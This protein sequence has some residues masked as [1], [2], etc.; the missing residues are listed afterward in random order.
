MEQLDSFKGLICGPQ[1]CDTQML[2]LGT[3]H[4]FSAL[5]PMYTQVLVAKQLM[6]LLAMW[7]YVCI[8]LSP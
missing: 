8:C 3:A 1:M 6:A 2:T 4:G 5:K 7:L